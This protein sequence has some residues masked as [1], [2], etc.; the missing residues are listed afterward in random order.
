MFSLRPAAKEDAFLI[1]SLV[2]AA[3]LNPT[4]LDWRRFTVAVLPNGEVIGCVQVKPHRDGTQE[5]A[6]LVVREDWRGRGVARALM[7]HELE[8]HA[9]P[10]YLMCRAGLGPFYRQFGFRPLAR[11]RATFGG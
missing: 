6:S 9:G 1:R 7:R 8:I 3:R 5:L 11:C 4:G 10:L 2:H